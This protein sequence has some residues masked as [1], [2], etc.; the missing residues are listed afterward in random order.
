MYRVEYLNTLQLS[1][2][3]TTIQLINHTR[4]TPT[5]FLLTSIVKNSLLPLAP[6]ATPRRCPLAEALRS[7]TGSFFSLCSNHSSAIQESARETVR[8]CV[9]KWIQSEKRNLEKKLTNAKQS[10]VNK[11]TSG[12]K[13]VQ[14]QMEHQFLTRTP[15]R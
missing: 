2:H 14:R 4:N 8:T 5:P 1:H 13:L 6:F 12:R 15:M 7:G 10:G 3:F 11:E 9:E